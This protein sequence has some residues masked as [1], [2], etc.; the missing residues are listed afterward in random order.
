M[1]K[2]NYPKNNSNNSKIYDNII[3]FTKDPI[4]LCILTNNKIECTGRE[5]QEHNLEQTGKKIFMNMNDLC[6]VFNNGDIDCANFRDPNFEFIRL[7]PY[8]E[9]LP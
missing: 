6:V 1:N 9:P 3:D 8:C 5:N 7:V 4:N 2:D